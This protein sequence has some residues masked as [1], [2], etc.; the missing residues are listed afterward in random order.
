[1]MTPTLVENVTVDVAEP[2]AGGASGFWVNE[3]VASPG[4]DEQARSTG[5][6]NPETDVTV[7]VAVTV[8]GLFTVAAVGVAV[9]VKS[10][11]AATPVPESA[12]V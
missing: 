6:E 3:Q 2:F 1:M 9:I 11:P 8:P 4:S 12:T 7:T 5:D 10:G